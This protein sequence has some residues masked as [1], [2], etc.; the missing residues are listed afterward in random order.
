MVWCRWLIMHEFLNTNKNWAN[1]F[2]INEW[3][4]WEVSFFNLVDEQV[5]FWK[6]ISENARL[7][8]Q[9]LKSG[10]TTLQRI[11]VE[12]RYSYLKCHTSCGVDDHTASSNTGLWHRPS[13]SSRL[14]FCIVHAI[15]FWGNP[16]LLP[17]SSR[18][19]QTG[20][21]PGHPSSGRTRQWHIWVGGEEFGEDDWKLTSPRGD[22]NGRSLLTSTKV[23]CGLWVVVELVS[24][25]TMH[26]LDKIDKVLLL[27]FRNGGLNH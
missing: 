10:Q 6:Q 22:F 13:S 16:L 4:Y 11:S 14:F 19:S 25:Y 9:Y 2:H 15:V 26:L 12:S 7:D 20:S 24:N 3:L 1:W 27:Y 17:R 5:C 8:W 21:L 23:I 18:S